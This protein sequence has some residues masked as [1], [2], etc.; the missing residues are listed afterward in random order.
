M[1]LLYILKYSFQFL[2]SISANAES[3]YIIDDFKNVYELSDNSIKK[4]DHS[5][6]QTFVYSELRKGEISSVDAANPLR[7]LVHFYDNGEIVF[8]DNTLT[9]QQTSLNLNEIGIYDASKV[10]S[11]FDN[12]LWVFRKSTQTLVRL[13]SRGKVVGETSNLSLI[14]GLD[15]IDCTELKE[16]GNFLYFHTAEGQI[17]IFD[18]YGSYKRRVDLGGSRIYSTKNEVILFEREGSVYAY[19]ARLA[20][21][22]VF[23]KAD[24]LGFKSDKIISIDYRHALV[25]KGD[26]VSLYAHSEP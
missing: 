19:N 22:G 8:L 16:T 25:S 2:W 17:L 20:D 18:Q 6:K 9:V 7:I 14:S 23:I 11:S 13:N 5:G 10:A 26:T 4:Y 1:I 15:E 3:N 21:E 24:D 12:H